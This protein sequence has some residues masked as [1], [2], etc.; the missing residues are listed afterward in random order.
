MDTC[1]FVV[2]GAGMIGSS[3]ALALADAGHSVVL[4]G[5]GE[6]P[7]TSTHEGVFASHYDEGRITRI[8]DPDLLWAKWAARSIARYGEIE[9]RS[10]IGFHT[11][12]GSVRIAP[13]ES[14]SL[15]RAKASANAQDVAID[16]LVGREFAHRCPAFGLSDAFTVLWEPP[17]AGHVN[18]RRMVAAIQA[19]AI[20][21]GA[22]LIAQIA[23]TIRPEGDG[24]EITL[25]N[26]DKLLA[27]RVLVATGP[28]GAD[29]G[30][31][32]AAP[33]LKVYGRTV[34]QFQI[35]PGDPLFA[36]LPSFI[37]ALNADDANYSFYGIPPVPY[38]GGGLWLKTGGGARTDALAGP[39]DI[40]TW[41]HAGG[42]AE[43]VRQVHDMSVRTFPALKSAR[44]RAEPC[45][46]SE[47][48][49]EHPFIGRVPGAS[50][51]G[52]ALGCNGY[53]AKSCLEVG[54]LAAAMISV[55]PGDAFEDAASVHPRWLE[56][57]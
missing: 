11:A 19:C 9:Q 18:P 5:P 8:V 36:G 54:R 22:R 50:Q 27:A 40:T 3:A 32:P 57:G 49:T 15:A 47:T 43:E 13:T 33:D 41:F 34:V 51:I 7:D 38:P 39:D 45:A 26:G 21:E 46:L 53:A 6:P 20:A 14:D 35:A 29:K 4:V 2:V 31:L 44:W 12:C 1:D 42:S 30:L 23:V 55:D 48:A 37:V 25:G 24:V 17:P 16:V 28:H 10:G 56:R 52:I